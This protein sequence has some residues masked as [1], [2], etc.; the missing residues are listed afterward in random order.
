MP[1]VVMRCEDGPPSVPSG[2]VQCSEC[3]RDC[4]LSTY[5]GASTLAAAKEADEAEPDLRELKIWC[6]QCAMIL[7]EAMNA[8]RN[9]DE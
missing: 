3:G 2:V 4:W 5:S 6:M 8:T 7:V 1:A 9:Q